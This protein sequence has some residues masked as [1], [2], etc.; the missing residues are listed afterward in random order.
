MSS[1]DPY[2]DRSAELM[3]LLGMLYFVIEVF[4]TDETFGEEL[5]ESDNGEYRWYVLVAMSPP[6]PV[7]IFQMVSGLKDKLPKGY[8]VKKVGQS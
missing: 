8:P 7:V 1:V 2:D 4:R 3:D 5:S 6:L